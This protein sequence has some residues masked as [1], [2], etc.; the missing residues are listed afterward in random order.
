MGNGGSASTA[1]HFTCDINKGV[2]INL[3]KKFKVICLNDNLPTLLAYGN[4]FSYEDIFVEPM[5]NF[6]QP[7]DLVIGFSGS[8]NSPNVLKA[9]EWANQMDAKTFSLTG[10]DGGKLSKISHNAFVAPVRDMQKTEDIHLM[11]CHLIM[12]MLC[13][14][15][16]PQALT[17]YQQKKAVQNPSKPQ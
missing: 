7:G 17:C 13:Y 11:I 6:L 1:S 8:G 2:C 12:Q 16:N 14:Q 15:L 3:E 10:F 4:D 9:F 5:K